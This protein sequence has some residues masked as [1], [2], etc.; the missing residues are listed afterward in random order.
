M[1]AKLYG[2]LYFGLELA[3]EELRTRPSISCFH[4]G[5]LMKKEKGGSRWAA[6]TTYH[7]EIV[8]KEHTKKREESSRFLDSARVPGRSEGAKKNTKSRS[9][10]TD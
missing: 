7:R 8:W 6:T 10:E 5:R 4:T 3:S 2:L 1:V 9:G